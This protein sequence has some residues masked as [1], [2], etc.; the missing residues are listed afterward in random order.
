M[1]QGINLQSVSTAT[2][3]ANQQNIFQKAKT[4]AIEF[5]DSFEKSDNNTKAKVNTALAGGSIAGTIITMLGARVSEKTVR[6]TKKGAEEGAKKAAEGAKNVIKKQ[7][8]PL[9]WLGALVAIA[10]S[11]GIIALNFKSKDS[12]E[13]MTATTVAEPAAQEAQAEQAQTTADAQVAQPVAEETK[14]EETEQPAQTPATEQ[15]EA[16]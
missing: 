10:S 4:K 15:V 11:A 9:K 6:N 7:N 3:V 2:P 5:K 13:G 12:Q 16:K 1:T 14:K 8:T